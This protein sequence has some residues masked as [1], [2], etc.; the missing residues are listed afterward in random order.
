MTPLLSN[1]V[2]ANTSAPR[3]G[4]EETG[5]GDGPR[6]RSSC[7]VMTPFERSGVMTFASYQI[8]FNP[9][10]FGSKEVETRV[11]GNTE[12]T[13]TR[14]GVVSVRFLGFMNTKKGVMPTRKRRL[15]VRARGT[16]APFVPTQ[17]PAAMKYPVEKEIKSP[18][19]FATVSPTASGKHIR[20]M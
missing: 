7:V 12:D 10:V 3:E 4:A 11:T 15:I 14:V 17:T 19:V 5:R 20:K 18:S 8:Y 2:I 9:T 6:E 13:G 1:G 16:T